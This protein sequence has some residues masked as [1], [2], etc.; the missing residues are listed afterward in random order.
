MTQL[1]SD[2]TDDLTDDLI[3]DLLTDL[4]RT[5]LVGPDG[6]RLRSEGPAGV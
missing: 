4:G 1:T 5:R 3:D 6:A 2:L